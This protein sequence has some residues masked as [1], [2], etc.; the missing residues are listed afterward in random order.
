MRG[1]P[2]G[3]SGGCHAPLEHCS[4]RRCRLP[5]ACRSRFA[6]ASAG[7]EQGR[8]GCRRQDAVLLPATDDRRAKGL[9]QGGGTRRRNPGFRRGRARTAGAARRQCR[10]R[11]RRLRAHHNATGEGPEHRGGV[12]P[13]Q[14]FFDGACD[15][16]GQGGEVQIAGRPQGHE[17][18]R[19]GAR[20]VDQ[21]VRQHS[22]RQSRPQAG[23]R[24]DHRCRRDGGRRR[25]HAAR[26]DRRPR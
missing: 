18:R 10:H 22:S 7:K 24:R 17:D 11:V 19:H 21:H 9:F 25:H 12:P 2:R 4:C 14:I 26:R 13:G 23:R 5:R 20:I 15:E 16:Q 1:R 8:G 3:F 6:R